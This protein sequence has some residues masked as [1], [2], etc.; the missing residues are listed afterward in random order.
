MPTHKYVIVNHAY[1]RCHY[2][3][4]RY[5]GRSNEERQSSFAVMPLTVSG[6]KIEYFRAHGTAEDEEKKENGE[7]GCVLL[8]RILK[9]LQ[10]ALEKLLLLPSSALKHR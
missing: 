1:H 4:C 7:W 5:R 2:F 3:F 9:L 6:V 8:S 10:Q